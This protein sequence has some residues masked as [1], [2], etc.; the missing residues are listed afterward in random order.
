MKVWTCHLDEV[1]ARN[2]FTIETF[3]ALAQP[4]RSGHSQYRVNNDR[5]PA[6]NV[7]LIS[8]ESLY[9]TLTLYVRHD[10]SVPPQ[11][12]IIN[13]FASKQVRR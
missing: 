9:E 3:I 11:Y 6:T 13:E 12:R 5:R 4:R 1:I 8:I 10:A 2:V 7:R